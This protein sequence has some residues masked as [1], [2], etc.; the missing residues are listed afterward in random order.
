LL[1]NRKITAGDSASVLQ[2]TME[3]LKEIAD[4]PYIQDKRF[5]YVHKNTIHKAAKLANLIARRKPFSKGNRET[6]ILAMLTL[7]SING[8]KIANYREDMEKLID[9]L[10]KDETDE[11]CQW[12]KAH[13]VD[14][15]YGNP[16]FEE[17]DGAAS[18][19]A[20]TKTTETT[21]TTKTTGGESGT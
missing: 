19:G 7:L 5:F 20:T 12:I 21:E 14:D 9:C 18:E 17:D 16:A 13:V 2:V 11:V 10:E 1:L 4:I 15:G 3:D 8:Y 6:A